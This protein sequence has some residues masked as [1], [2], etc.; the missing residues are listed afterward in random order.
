MDIKH[1][2]TRTV[3][4]FR[5]IKLNTKLGLTPFQMPISSSRNTNVFVIFVYQKN[6]KEEER[7]RETA[8]KVY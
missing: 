1:I 6:T 7:G 8:I 3:F 4:V 5:V 2:L